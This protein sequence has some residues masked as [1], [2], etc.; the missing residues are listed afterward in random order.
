NMSEQVSIN[1]S[2]VKILRQDLTL[3]ETEGIVFYARPDLK[4][5]SGYGN[6]ISTRGG[7]SIKKEL[8]EIGSANLTESVVTAAGSLKAEFI[9]HA[10]GPA[11]Q[12]EDIETKLRK[13]IENALKTISDKGIKKVGFPLMGIGFYGIAPDASI[14]ILLESIKSFVSQNNSI[15]E[16]TICANDNREFRMLSSKFEKFN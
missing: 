14:N 11:F 15:E 5:G 12:E 4:L 13:T 7:P 1:K 16:I 8:D 10:V 3:L 9:I 6:A 2:I